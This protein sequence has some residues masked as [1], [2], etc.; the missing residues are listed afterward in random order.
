MVKNNTNVW[1]ITTIVLAVLLIAAIVAIMIPKTNKN[2]FDSGNVNIAE[3]VKQKNQQL[4][5]ND[6]SK[7]DK[8][9]PI[10]MIEFSDF[11]CPFCAKFYSETYKQIETDYINTGK[12]RIV[13]RDLPLSFH[14]NAQK[15]AE[16]AECA[17]EQGKFWEMHDKLFENQQALEI[18]DLKKYASDLN[19]DATKFNNCLD[20]GKYA[21]EIQKD[22]A[23]AE[24]NGISGTPGV[25]INGQLVSGAYPYSY[26]KS[27]FDGILSGKPVQNPQNPE[28]QDNQ[29][30][31]QLADTSNDPEIS[32]TIVNDKNCASCDTSQVLQVTK[33]LFPT[34]KTTTVE[35][36]S[37]EGKKLISDLSIN[38][39]PAYLFDENVAKAANYDKVAQ[40]LDKAGNN[41]VI[42]PAASGASKYLNPPSADDDPV[43]GDKN[44]KVTIIEFSDFECPFCG[45]FYDDAYK[46]INEQY[47][48]TGKVKIV[49]RDFPLS[50]HPNAHNAAEAAE[51]ADEQGKFLEMHDKIFENQKALTKDDLKKYAKDLGLDQSKFDSCLDTGKYKQEVDKDL[52]DGSK[53]GV[54]GTPSFFINGISLT[55][56]QP[57]EAFKEIIDAE[58]AK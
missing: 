17:N 10:V 43:I 8:K 4:S 45:K 16:A 29:N 48:K 37:E 1:K 52:E 38:A 3:D 30:P 23:D 33:T 39:L 32:L 46:Q 31:D 27:I 42:N 58:L 47:I 18:N 56:A 19:L 11:Q 51:C 21:S 13:F 15:A 44:A 50:F 14:E 41:Y 35:F 20:T 7:G 5:D 24:V 2:L 40:A 57:F 34:A 28:Q 22:A 53:V 36:D 54:S 25:L 26:F 9:A 6:P 49:F 12:V 55:G